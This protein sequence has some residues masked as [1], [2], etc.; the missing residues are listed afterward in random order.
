MNIQKFC[1]KYMFIAIWKEFSGYTLHSRKIWNGTSI[2]CAR[3][4]LSPTNPSHPKRKWPTLLLTWHNHQ[5]Q[6]TNAWINE[7]HS[8]PFYW[9]NRIVKF[10]T[11]T[12]TWTSTSTS[13]AT[14]GPTQ[15]KMETTFWLKNNW[16]NQLLVKLGS[17][18]LQMQ[19]K[20]FFK[21]IY[22]YYILLNF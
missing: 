20:F 16:F 19:N 21:N 6:S 1:M 5:I 7:F 8:E 4:Y 18:Y 15:G 17:F 9:M 2:K 10:K 3:Y 12:I 22:L 13:K 11:K 14:F